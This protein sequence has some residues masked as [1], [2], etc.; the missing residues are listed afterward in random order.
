[1]LHYVA[2]GLIISLYCVMPLGTNW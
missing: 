2:T 1:M